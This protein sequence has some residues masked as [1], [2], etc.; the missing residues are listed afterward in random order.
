MLLIAVALLAPGTAWA[1]S[2]DIGCIE[3]KLGQ[4]AMQ[5]IGDSVVAAADN[6]SDP[7]RALDSDREALIAARDACRATGNW[8]SNKAQ[9]AISYT[10]ARA[11]KFGA[12][13]VFRTDGLDAGKLAT[14]FAALPL[15]DRR[16]LIA[17]ASATALRAVAAVG[18]TPKQR[19]HVL[20]YFAALA[21][22][23]FYPADF[24][25]G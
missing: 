25:T 24:A 4:A 12:E 20:L 17:K 7:S 23:E 13:S 14:A 3:A 19:R 6:G 16:S 22:L 1:A 11:T 5:R 2:G 15:P 9:A 10:Q 21:G 8:S 18:A